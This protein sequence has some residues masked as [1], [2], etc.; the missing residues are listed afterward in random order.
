MVDLAV[1]SDGQFIFALATSPSAIL[2]LNA[3]GTSLSVAS[4]F[5]ELP[6][7]TQSI[8]LA[9]SDSYLYL[10]NINP[11]NVVVLSVSSDGALS[12]SSTE[13]VGSFSGV[14]LHVSKEFVFLSTR[15]PSTVTVWSRNSKTGALT[16]FQNLED[17][18]PGPHVLACASDN[19]RLW[20]AVVQPA[21]YPGL[22]GFDRPTL[23]RLWKNI[24]FDAERT[25]VDLALSPSDSVIGVV[26]ANL[27]SVIL[28]RLL[29][30]SMNTASP[31]YVNS[32]NFRDAV[33]LTFLSDTQFAVVSSGFTPMLAF[34]TVGSAIMATTSTSGQ[35]VTSGSSGTTS[36]VSNVMTRIHLEECLKKQSVVDKMLLDIAKYDFSLPRMN[37]FPPPSL[38][39][40]VV[41]Q[42]R[43]M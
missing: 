26:D 30:S 41:P 25:L 11:P 38:L 33:R 5:D 27:G 8:H 28:L 34:G 16:H 9:A 36:T 43:G 1:S 40:L 29:G 42:V 18:G 20:A 32:E 31:E 10:G 4:I 13:T 2:T 6:V 21:P 3:S 39:C 37:V 23:F 19:R 15:G 35:A 12:I 24:T 22:L 14:K 7:G 17:I